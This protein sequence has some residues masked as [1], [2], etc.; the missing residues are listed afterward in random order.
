[1]CFMCSR[2]NAAVCKKKS[3]HP[4][5]DRSLAPKGQG[6]SSDTPKKLTLNAVDLYVQ[7]DTQ[8]LISTLNCA[9]VLSKIRK[10]PLNSKPCVHTWL[11]SIMPHLHAGRAG[12]IVKPIKGMQAALVSRSH[13]LAHY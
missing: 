3:R 2:R 8:H 5:F 11:K 7:V 6:H 4:Q 13:T 1:M 10:N 12:E 9:G